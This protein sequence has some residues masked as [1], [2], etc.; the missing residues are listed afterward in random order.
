MPPAPPP[1]SVPNETERLQEILADPR[2]PKRSREWLEKLMNQVRI[3][4]FFVL[5]LLYAFF[6]PSMCCLTTFELHF[7]CLDTVL[8]PLTHDKI[9]MRF[10]CDFLMQLASS[11]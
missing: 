1:E 5:F 10:A 8:T 7:T 11:N 2:F 3:A 9:R 4:A 6:V